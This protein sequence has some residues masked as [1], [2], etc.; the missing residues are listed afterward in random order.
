M[1]AMA[2]LCHADEMSSNELVR[3]YTSTLAKQQQF[4]LKFTNRTVTTSQLLVSVS[5][6]PPDGRLTTKTNHASGTVITDG[7]RVAVRTTRWGQLRSHNP[8]VAASN[9]EYR[10]HTFDGREQWGY[11]RNPL[12][13]SE[14]LGRLVMNPTPPDRAIWDAVRLSYPGHSLLGYINRFTMRTDEI[15][16]HPST[17]LAVR[18]ELENVGGVDCYVLDVKSIYGRGALWLDPEHGYN[19]AH[20]YFNIRTGDVSKLKNKPIKAPY[21]GHFYLKDVSFKLV[22]NVWFPAQGTF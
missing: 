8:A 16:R 3:N 1:A 4:A 6:K 15:L 19:I 17:K 22:D 11:Y 18:K 12:D 5:G 9:P 2:S 10:R 20:A 7:R 21:K 14:P 13:K